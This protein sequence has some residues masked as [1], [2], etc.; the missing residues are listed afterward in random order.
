VP[1][2][3]WPASA[4]TAATTAASTGTGLLLARRADQRSR[5]F[6]SAGGNAMAVVNRGA[7]RAGGRGKQEERPEPMKGPR[8]HG[9]G[10]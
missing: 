8:S 9:T 6:Q 7:K 4:A 10:C 1:E 3:A 2:A 5:R